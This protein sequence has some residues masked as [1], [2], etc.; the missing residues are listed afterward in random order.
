VLLMHFDGNFVDAIGISTFTASGSSF[1]S[2]TA[3]F[4]QKLAS[5]GGSPQVH[6]VSSQELSIGTR[7]FTIEGRSTF[8]AGQTGGIVLSKCFWA[9]ETEAAGRFKHDFSV[10]VTPTLLELQWESMGAANATAPITT[11]ADV[12]FHWAISDDGSAMRLYKDGVLLQTRASAS[13]AAVTPPATPGSGLTVGGFI[14]GFAGGDPSWSTM[15]G[16][17]DELAMW[18]GY[19]KYTEASYS[20]PAAPYTFGA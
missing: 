3:G 14:T 8:G 19:A 13:A 20:V 11:A 15:N 17:I 6:G 12:E 7:Q 5:S 1:V 4:G 18:L 9:S 10:N 16:K 2:G